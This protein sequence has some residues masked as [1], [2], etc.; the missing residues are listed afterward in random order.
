MSPALS[1][2]E[3][4]SYCCWNCQVALHGSRFLFVLDTSSCVGLSLNFGSVV[5]DCGSER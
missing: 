3:K 5:S 2:C 1:T 4:R